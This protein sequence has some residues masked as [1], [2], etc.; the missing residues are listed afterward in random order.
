MH[1]KFGLIMAKKKACNLQALNF[2]KGMV[3]CP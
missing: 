3:Q 1:N 2:F